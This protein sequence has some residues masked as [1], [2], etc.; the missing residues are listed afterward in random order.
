MFFDSNRLVEK[1][2]SKGKQLDRL[3]SIVSSGRLFR[4]QLTGSPVMAPASC[5]AIRRP[6]RRGHAVGLH[7]QVAKAAPVRRESWRFNARQRGDVARCCW[8]DGIVGKGVSGH[9]W[10]HVAL[11]AQ[12][13]ALWR[14]VVVE[15]LVLVG[16]AIAAATVVAFLAA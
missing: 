3:R 9:A 4:A 13:R 6:S 11:D 1:F 16:L 8:P 7:E 12:Q 2:I 5:E 15:V 14:S 10:G